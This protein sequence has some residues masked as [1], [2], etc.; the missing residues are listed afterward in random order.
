MTEREDSDAV[1]VLCRNHGFATG[2]GDTLAD[3]VRE[4]DGQIA[5]RD[6]KFRRIMS[7]L[8]HAW[9]VDGSPSKEALDFCKDQFE[10]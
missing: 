7:S 10:E 4:V 8:Y 2:H 9:S 3:I 6:A 1:L 5:E